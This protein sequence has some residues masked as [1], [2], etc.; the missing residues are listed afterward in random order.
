MKIGEFGESK[1]KIW[2]GLNI[3]INSK[4]NFKY[5]WII[6]NISNIESKVE[7]KFER[8]YFYFFFLLHNLFV[9][10]IELLLFSFLL[11]IFYYDKVKSCICV[12][13]RD[14]TCFSILLSSFCCPCLTIVAFVFEWIYKYMS[15]W[16][17]LSLLNSH[18]LFI[19]YIVCC[20]ASV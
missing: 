20:K 1:K 12:M 2:G 13:K 6:R 8:N 14:N 4:C 7:M 17:V 18:D 16:V 19:L 3:K 5:Q 9:R 15:L 11:Q 10:V